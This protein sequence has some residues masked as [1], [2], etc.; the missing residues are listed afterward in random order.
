MTL[1]LATKNGHKLLEVRRMLEPAGYRV[2]SERDLPSPLPEVEET[3]LSF[4]ENALIKARAA[5]EAT[6]LP[7]IADDSGLAVDALD[8]APGIFSA[9]YAGAHGDDAANNKKLL[10]EL[11]GVP[12]ERRGARYVCAI[13]YVSCDREFTVEGYCPGV[14]ATEP[15]GSN[16]FGYDPLFVSERG[17]FGVI[18]P[19]EKDAVSHRHAALLLLLDELRGGGSGRPA[20]GNGQQEGDPRDGKPQGRELREGKPQWS[21]PRQCEPRE[22]KAQKGEPLKNDPRDGAAQGGNPREGKS[23]S[24][25]RGSGAGKSA[26]A[27]DRPAQRIAGDTVLFG[28]TFNPP[29]LGHVELARAALALPGTGELW[30]IPSGEPVHKDTSG[31]L[32]SGEHRLA[33]CRLALEG[34]PGA[35]VRDTEVKSPARNY[36]LLTVRKCKAEYPERRFV[37]LLG[38][39]S[40]ESFTSWYH[41]KELLREVPLLAVRRVGD[42]DFT[43]AVERLR[44]E[45]GDVR[46]L[47]ADIPGI[48]STEVRGRISRGE[49]FA[50]LLPPAVAEYIAANRLYTA[51]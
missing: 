1:F 23:E 27:G 50:E 31:V 11:R 18:S 14:I 47:D 32:S 51:G 26:P 41:Y 35:V 22:I 20:G 48:S 30:M 2:A 44:S 16:G 40:V 3:G 9:R 39:D 10:R 6:G 43:G 12:P 7:S 34:L 28:G 29:H 21:E 33:M 38:G 36:S 15:R 46:V 8:G 42:R 24:G 19:E 49:P 37:F 25:P 17:C 4:R 13:A 5:F 45:G